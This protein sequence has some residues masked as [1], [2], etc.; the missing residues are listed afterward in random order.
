MVFIIVCAC[1]LFSCKTKVEYVDREVIKYQTISVHDT[2]FQ[3][4]H[5][6]I[7]VSITQK[8][9][10]VFNT[11]YVEKIKWRDHVVYSHD[12]I[13]RDSIQ[14]VQRESVK[15]VTK[16]PKIFWLTL[17]I[18]ILAVLYICYKIKKKFTI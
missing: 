13:F 14:V 5:D 15:E 6:S 4:T 16:I 12:T 2:L 3:D 17:V 18:S 1:M 8:G 11:K 10:T 7:Y 9:D